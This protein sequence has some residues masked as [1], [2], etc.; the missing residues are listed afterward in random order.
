MQLLHGNAGI[1]LKVPGKPKEKRNIL[2]D[3]N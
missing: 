2:D 3:D 1:Q